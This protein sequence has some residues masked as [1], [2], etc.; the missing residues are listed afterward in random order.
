MCDPGGSETK[1]STTPPVAKYAA[2]SSCEQYNGVMNCPTGSFCFNFDQAAVGNIR[3]DPMGTADK[4]CDGG[5]SGQDHRCFSDGQTYY[6]GTKYCWGKCDEKGK[7]VP[8]THNIV[9]GRSANHP[10]Y[11]P[12]I[13]GVSAS[14][15]EA[16]YSATNFGDFGWSDGWDWSLVR[17]NSNCAT[18]SY[19]IG[20]LTAEE[21]DASGFTAVDRMTAAMDHSKSASAESIKQL[22]LKFFS[23]PVTENCP[24]VP[25]NYWMN[26]P[27]AKNRY[28]NLC[29]PVVSTGKAGVLARGIQ[30]EYPKE[31]N[32]IMQDWC[33]EV[34]G[35]PKDPRCSCLNHRD[36]AN[37]W[38]T[39]YDGALQTGAV[40]NF[41]DACW[42]APCTRSDI[43]YMN[44]ENRG[45]PPGGI[46]PCAQMTIIIGSDIKDSVISQYA[47]C[48]PDS[49][50]GGGG[51]DPDDPGSRGSSVVLPGDLQRMREQ[52]AP[53]YAIVGGA[54]AALG[55]GIMLLG[56]L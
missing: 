12:M 52:L 24:L 18:C 28:Q 34:G 36:P 17:N 33:A 30:E 32:V 55:A 49:G 13:G 7:G 39:I 50:G 20:R 48:D 38:H 43:F 2:A 25:E 5:L 37:A 10:E 22:K 21:K 54:L 26:D 4:A 51:S 56:L 3:E 6:H 40:W 9:V 1:K 46:P 23:T 53:K 44:Y 35:N 15:S 42:Y 11:C 14:K 27:L 45:C 41:P 19:D 8:A 31:T 47:N 29:L 16:P